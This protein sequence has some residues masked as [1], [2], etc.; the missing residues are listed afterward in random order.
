MNNR[1]KL[2]LLDA[3]SLIYRAYFAFIRN[4]RY[5]SKGLNTSAIFGFTNTLDDLLQK[6]KPS[7]IAVVFDPPKPT[8]RH[9]LF[10]E[11]KAKREAMPEDI[12]KSI[13]YIK[14]LI[15]AFNI[16]I[17][18]IEGYEADDVIGTLAKKAEEKG[19]IT[20]MVTPDK[21][22]AQLVSESIFMYKPGKRGDEAE[23]WGEHEVKECFHVEHPDQVI[24]VLALWG[25]SADNIPGAPGIGEKTAKK[26]I[27]DYKS[28]EDIFNN[29]EEL[30]GKQKENIERNKDQIRLSKELVTLIL[31]VPVELNE[32][33]LKT[34]EPDE[35]KLT[36]LFNELEFK[37]IAK[38]I[39]ERDKLVTTED[40]A[41]QA[42]LF[43]EDDRQ[44]NTRKL[45]NIQST[46]HNYYII[47]NKEKI[48][49]LIRQLQNQ[50]EFCFD[51]ETTG[52]NVHESEIVGIS[53]S[54]KDHEAYYLPI[55][56]KREEAQAVLCKFREIFENRAIRKIGQNIKYDIQILQSYEIQVRGELFDTMLAHY[57]LQPDMRHN[58]NYLSEVYLKYSPVSIEELI[59]NKGKGQLSMR[60]VSLEKVA[61]YAAED[62]DITWQL[63]G[64]LEK[65]LKS[66]GLHELF[67]KIEMPLVCVLADM[68]RSGVRLNIEDLK[69]YGDILRNEIL[70]LDKEIIQL[71]GIEFNIAS[72]KQ[73]G[74]VLFEKMKIVDNVKRTKTRQYST[75][76]EVLKHLAEK[77]I[78]IPKILEYRSLKKLLT[79]YVDVL[80]QLINKK[81]GKIHTSFNQ[82]I[83]STG[84]LS[85][86]NPN[87]QNIPIREERGREIRKAFVPTSND[88]ILLSAD[89]SQIELR[90]MAHMSK[91]PN[92]IEAFNANE[93][94]H[95]TTAAKINR[96][97]ASQVTK[98]MRSKA[99]TANFGII[100]GISAFGLSQRL[101]IPRKES[102]EF[103]EEYFN[104]YPKVKAYM[105]KSIKLARDKGYVVTI[106]GRRRYLKDINSKNA[107][108]RGMAERN[109]INA[110]IQGSAA[111]IIKMAMIRIHKIIQEN[112]YK[113]RMILQVHDE[114][115][116][117]VYKPELEPISEMVAETMQNAI[118]LIIP[119]LV[120]IGTG[121]NWLEAH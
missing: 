40:K 23:V 53:F 25:D 11:Y 41:S 109:A 106:M 44:T 6:E 54:F 38:R 114:L 35:D 78:I 88:Y 59:G 93:D 68:E 28:I 101:S 117:D 17:I 90:L 60:R 4:P 121:D 43:K 86:N 22:Y 55:T 73:L 34:R 46:S 47:D 108:V 36:D 1:K 69:K 5:S 67:E 104:T 30:K 31:D 7:H 24:D 119:L 72:P 18:E 39:L 120:D 61:E 65:D 92:M 102:R 87:L 74:E 85:S 111:D 62:A 19:F 76:E 29:V 89:Y 2:L 115:V 97:N 12:K 70:E 33:E 116:F 79:T 9:K 21:D 13:P 91:D 8:F 51:T 112:N 83:T 96:I 63:K 45:S 94:I 80:P 110:P 64:K 32:N 50:K 105:D 98:E 48:S 57:I 15:R 71:A 56:E 107:V 16:P 99:K 14:D 66:N 77:H 81:T 37:S 27:S 103:I 52:L 10:K 58:L 113:S 3:Y 49:D 118:R 84:R 82:A 20:Y 42:T 75:S 100:Y 26:L 95:V